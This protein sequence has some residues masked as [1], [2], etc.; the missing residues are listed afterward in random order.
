M[1]KPMKPISLQLYINLW[2][3]HQFYMKTLVLV[4]CFVI[5]LYF[6]VLKL[7]ILNIIYQVIM[8]WFRFLP[9]NIH[10]KAHLEQQQIG[11]LLG[12]SGY[13]L[14]RY[15]IT[16]LGNPVI[17]QEVAFNRAHS[18]SRMVIERAFGLMKSIFKWNV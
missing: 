1:L 3:I 12:D 8:Y 15:S 5:I 14:Q 4:M 16:P 6:N 10:L 7:K 2:F 17:P 11:H 18:S 13:P 9:H